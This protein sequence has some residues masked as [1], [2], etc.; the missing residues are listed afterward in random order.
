MQKNLWCLLVLAVT[1]SPGCAPGEVTYAI[2][3][4]CTAEQAADVQ[5]AAEEWNFVATR[6]LRLVGDRQSPDYL[7]LPAKNKDAAGLEQKRLGLIRIDPEAKWKYVALH[8]FGHALGVDHIQDPNAVM[9]GGLRDNAPSSLTQSDLIA[10]QLA[11]A[12]E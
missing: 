10:C 7:I 5:W 3:P 2:D 8:E 11:S 9:Y 4:A 12:C 6:K 1:L